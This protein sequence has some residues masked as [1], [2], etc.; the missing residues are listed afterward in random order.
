MA[1]DFNICD[2]SDAGVA[3]A[4]LQ[5]AYG[6]WLTPLHGGLATTSQ[7]FTA[8]RVY[9]VQFTVQKT[10]QV[11]GIAYVVGATAAGN[12]RAAIIGPTANTA[13]TALG[14]AVLIE[15][16]SVAQGTINT[17]QLIALTATSLAPGVY[18]AALQASDATGTYMRHSNQLQA[19]GFSQTYDRGGGYGA[20]TTPTPAVT[21]TGS[22]LPGLRIRMV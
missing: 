13:D 6:R 8:G 15:S 4:A 14:A 18:Y 10:Q 1:D 21:D 5:V 9:L 19:A 3:L 22:A 16:A 17:P 12:V 2:T 20:F 7:T 11:D